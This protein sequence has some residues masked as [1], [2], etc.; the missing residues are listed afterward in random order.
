LCG[1]GLCVRDAV[2]VDG[3][4]RDRSRAW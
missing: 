4:C 1:V 2:S 3:C